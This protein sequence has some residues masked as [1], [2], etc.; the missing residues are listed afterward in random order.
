MPLHS[1]DCHLEFGVYH[2]P[3]IFSIV[4]FVLNFILLKL[5]LSFFSIVFV[6]ST[7]VD[8]SARSLIVTLCSTV[9]C[10]IF[11]FMNTA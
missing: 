9:L 2:F 1:R 6:T 8:I 5:D 10:I 11:H 3:C 4:L 7:H